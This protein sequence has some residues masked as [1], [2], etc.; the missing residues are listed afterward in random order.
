MLTVDKEVLAI[1]RRLGLNQYESKT[2]LALVS[3]DA[4]TATELSD[5]ANI[6]RPRV[7]DVLAK[8]EKKGF[9][10]TRP[11]RPTRYAAI[12]VG[13]A[14]NALKKEREESFNKEV[15]EL[16]SLEEL[17]SSAL[18]TGVPEQSSGEEVFVIKDRKN[19]YATLEE[20]ISN[21]KK[22]V[23]IASTKEGLHRKRKHYGKLLHD[24]LKRGVRVKFVENPARI[25]IVDD[26]AF[27][28]LNDSRES[29]N[30]KAALIQS[31]YVAG[32]LK[33]HLELFE[34]GS[35]DLETK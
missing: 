12:S 25:V 23:F 5:A 11:G 28:F 8:L 30:D 35:L 9:V 21:A 14:L 29:K 26:H 13:T 2:Y 4:S 1:L 16:D 15:S 22:H 19:V 10:M 32:A 17:L 6:P 24:A 20:K 18:V 7:Y 31:K 27:I 33:E 3:A 34:N